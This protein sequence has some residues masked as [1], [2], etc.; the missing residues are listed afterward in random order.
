[1]QPRKLIGNE[2]CIAGRYEYLIFCFYYRLSTQ[3]IV[4]CVH[5]P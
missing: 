4:V 2:I 1:M 3:Y 5:G